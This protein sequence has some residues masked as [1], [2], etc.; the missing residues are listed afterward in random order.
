MAGCNAFQQGNTYYIMVR[1]GR[2]AY[3]QKGVTACHGA[4]RRAALFLSA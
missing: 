2:R 4:C 3:K 1:L